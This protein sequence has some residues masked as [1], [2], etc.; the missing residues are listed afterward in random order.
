MYIS[1]NIP[2]GS[3]AFETY[4]RHLFDNITCIG[5]VQR[6]D[7]EHQAS[8]DLAAKE[9]EQFLQ[10]LARVIEKHSEAFE[11]L[12]LAD[13][14]FKLQRD[15][16]FNIT[17]HGFDFTSKF[18]KDNLK[19]LRIFAKHSNSLVA[20]NWAGEL[21]SDVELNTVLRRGMYTLLL[22]SHKQR[23]VEAF[24]AKEYEIRN[25]TY[26][27]AVFLNTAYV[28]E[29]L[30][31]ECGNCT[32]SLNYFLDP[33]L[34]KSAM[35]NCMVAI[36]IGAM[37]K[38]IKRAATGTSHLYSAPF[39]AEQL[40]LS[41]IKS[42]HR[43]SKVQEVAS[44]CATQMIESIPSSLCQRRSLFV[45][46]ELLD[47]MWTSCLEEEADEFSWR[48]KFQSKREMIRIDLSDDYNFRNTTLNNFLD[49]AKSWI[50]R[51]INIAPLDIKGLLQVDIHGI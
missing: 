23:L 30:R 16:W 41:L 45:M 28:L 4:I 44:M 12:C 47:M 14:L 1:S 7:E 26:P 46:L 15:S 36:A 34:R 19:H 13:D 29:T 18:G 51:A 8:F 9:L 22:I 35:G 31:A 49:N 38:Y 5:E 48:S 2:K 27:E 20:E 10:P 32:R 3:V 37:T 33:K 40:A 42:C 24:P 43:V 11:K 21:E 25:L 6:D 17:V 39:V 50:T